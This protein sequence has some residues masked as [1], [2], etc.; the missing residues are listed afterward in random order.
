MRILY[1]GGS[2]NPIHHGHLICSRAVAEAAGYDTVILIPNQQSP[3]KAAV[4][5][6]ASAVDRLTLCRR[7]VSGDP[8]FRVDDLELTR[9]APSYTLD[10]VR[11][12]TARDRQPVHWLIGGDQLPALPQWHG[13]ESLLAEVNFVV[14]QRPGWSFNWSTQPEPIRRLRAN[15]VTAP[16]VQISSTD[17]RRRVRDGRPIDYLTPPAVAAYIRDHG[18]YRPAT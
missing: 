2:F 18:L 8:L 15:L 1:F 3:L 12:L 13:G 16:R 5:D 11:L 7:A 10:T 14:M 17:V 9:P 4:T 6:V